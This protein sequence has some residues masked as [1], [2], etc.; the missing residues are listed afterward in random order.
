MPNSP[1]FSSSVHKHLLAGLNLFNKALLKSEADIAIA[2]DVLEGTLDDYSTGPIIHFSL[3]PEHPY[4]F[5]FMISSVND[6]T[7]AYILDFILDKF[8]SNVSSFSF[9]LGYEIVSR[10]SRSLSQ[11]P[12]PSN[13]LPEGLDD[14]CRH[15]Q[16]VPTILEDLFT[17]IQSSFFEAES[18][19]RKTV[20]QSKTSRR[21]NTTRV[22]AEIEDR[23]SRALGSRFPETRESAEDIMQSTIDE[24]KDTLKF[25]F[26][27]L[28]RF[29]IA[30]LVRN[31]YLQGSI[32]QGVRVDAV[33]SLQAEATPSSPIA[34]GDPLQ[35]DLYFP[36]VAG[37]GEWRIL[38][39]HTF[40]SDMTRDN[41]LSKAVLG[42]LRGRKAGDVVPEFG[43]DVSCIIKVFATTKALMGQ[44]GMQVLRILGIYTMDKLKRTDWDKIGRYRAR[45]GREYIEK[46]KARK[47]PGAFFYDPMTCGGTPTQ[48]AT[49]ATDSNPQEV[50]DVDEV[51][52]A[53]APSLAY[54]ADDSHGSEC[55]AGCSRGSCILSRFSG[56]PVRS[57]GDQISSWEEKEV[58]EFTKS[59]FVLGRSGTGKTTVIVFKIFGIERAWQN[60]GSVGPRPRQLFITKS[61]LLADKVE[62]DYVNLLF[63]LSEDPDT[64]QYIRDRIHL[65]KLRRKNN[66]LDPDDA[67]GK[68]DDLPETFS[69]LQD[70]HFP[71]FITVDTL[72]SLLEADMEPPPSKSRYSRPQKRND[73]WLGHTDLVAF[74][75]FRREYWRH[76]PQDLTRE[77]GSSRGLRNRWSPHITPVD[78]GTYENLTNRNYAL[79]EAY[80]RLKRERRQRD[81]AD[82][83]HDLL[84][85]I[86][87]N[88]LK[89]VLVDFVRKMLNVVIVSLCRNPDGFLWAGD[90]AQ[91]ISIGSTFS[92]KELGAFV[93]RYQRSIRAVRG[94]PS[95][96]KGF[97]LLVNYRSHGGIVK[98]ANAI[99]QLLQQFPGAIDVLQPEA[100]IAGKEIPMFFHG[101]CLP[102]RERD[103]FLLS[104][105]RLCKL[106]SKQCIIVRDE[107]ARKKLRSDI[108]PVAIILTL[109]NSKGLEYD[110]VIL[111]NFF[112]ESANAN[113]WRH[114]TD[115]QLHPLEDLKHAPLIYEVRALHATPHLA[116]HEYETQWHLLDLG[117]VVEPLT[118]P[119]PLDTFADRSTSEEWSEAGKRLLNHGEFEEAA[120]AFENAGEVYLKAV[121]VA[122]Q[123]AGSRP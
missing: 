44:Y 113:L 25:F 72:W 6:V 18:S 51:M 108:G 33:T 19:T 55:H 57:K 35:A 14:R 10:L 4:A 52:D 13:K 29:E 17:L 23:L 82:R 59:S 12:Y 75:V 5:E 21:K 66:V 80:Q 91:T 78:R 105:G 86:K 90:T 69:E 37:F 122:C 109:F 115:A 79:F 81:L 88:G 92:F 111:Y 30:E 64:P 114:L 31:A 15:T 94:A 100:G 32:P 67:Q 106:G 112:G 60:R 120:M 16:M 8:S 76:L 62:Q 54:D 70:G 98:C 93:Y 58:V 97:Q 84:D 73:K 50:E 116:R 36:S 96:P 39:S 65:W 45:N 68:R 34:G 99:I 20:Q 77:L 63:S 40:L 85:G 74:D 110:D 26:T 104:T 27:L 83:T 61:R 9:S 118:T 107:A 2:V 101:E 89:G 103:F 56:L 119:Y 48:V 102:S 71:L 38:C 1:E 11:L 42:R 53:G 24:Q 87:E 41:A 123:P 43:I 22:H 28:Q 95:Q 121:A 46:C 49:I 117:L 47:S 7:S 3:R